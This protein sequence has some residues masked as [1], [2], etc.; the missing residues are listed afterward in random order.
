[1]TESLTLDQVTAAIEKMGLVIDEAITEATHFAD[2]GLDSLDRLEAEF[3]LE[4]EFGEDLNI[5]S[6]M[7]NVQTVGDLIR[8]VNASLADA[9]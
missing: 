4:E 7:A 1:M 5:G 6:E 2:L 3:A 9:A 8:T